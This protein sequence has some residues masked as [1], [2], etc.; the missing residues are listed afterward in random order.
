MQ[1]L[2]E[3]TGALIALF[4]REGYAR[5]EPPILQPADVFLDLSGEDIRRRM[6]VTQDATGAELC[7][8]PEYTIPVCRH[9]RAT[10]GTEPAAYA[11]CGPVFRLRAGE[12]GEFLQAGIE[13]IG[14]SDATAADAEILALALEGL[15]AVGAGPVSVRLGDMGLLD[16]V[17]EA[18][19]LPATAKRRVMRAVVS[20]RGL[21]GL[22]GS[23]GGAS[24]EHAGLLAALEGQAPQAARAF[25][26]DVLSIAGIT[27][28]GGRSAGEIAER[29]LERAANRSG[30]VPEE[31]RTV[32]TRY[33][34]IAG[35]PDGAAVAVRSLAREAGLDLEAALAAFEERV[36]FM[37]ARGLDV[38]AFGFR[39]DFA[40][41]LDYYTGFIFEAHAPGHEKPLVGGGR[42]DRLLRH[43][44]A[45]EPTPAVG[46]AFWLDR[47]AAVETGR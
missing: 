36:G 34:G 12:T 4:G 15:Q 37:A 28:V 9:H 32:L 18:L 23:E 5:L 43:L 33:L 8:R 31:A 13:S 39:A 25:V 42:Y 2:G 45:P 20:G 19:R 44:G 10:R 16:A 27:T 30:L 46:C 40:R 1:D 41:N 38:G 3:A 14:R 24:P 22:T 11:Y 17:I 47:I 35:D 26:E 29:F 6:F 7:L 21:A